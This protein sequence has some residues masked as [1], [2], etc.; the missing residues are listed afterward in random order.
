MW[1]N[2][3]ESPPLPGLMKEISIEGVRL[4]ITNVDSQMY[5]FDNHCPHEEFNLSLGC[6]KKSFV[7]CALH[8]YEFNLSTGRCSEKE[9]PEL[10]TYPV[11]VKDELI[12]VQMR[13]ANEL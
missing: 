3:L 2:T 7:R 4:V 12:F 1:F 13:E 9:I 6:I 8:G 10:V 11:K 5:C